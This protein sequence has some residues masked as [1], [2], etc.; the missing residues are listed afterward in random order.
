MYDASSAGVPTLPA[1]EPE[2]PGTILREEFL[3]PSRI[4]VS[5]AAERL[6]VTRQ[7]LH[8]VLSEGSAVSVDMALRLARFT[9]TSP[10]FWLNLQAQH[11]LWH[12]QR[13]L[14]KEIG[15]IPTIESVVQARA[16]ARVAAK[17]GKRRAPARKRG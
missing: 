3:E 12:Q 5:E 7:T 10:G 13:A 9:A 4:T 8:R 6:G 1:F 14:A 2:H 17:A 11:D 16:A 15:R